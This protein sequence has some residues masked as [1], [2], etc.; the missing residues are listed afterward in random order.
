MFSITNYA[1]T[2]VYVPKGALAAYQADDVWKKFW[3]IR[4]MESGVD[5]VSKDAVR[6]YARDGFIEVLGDDS[7]SRVEVYDIGGRLV[8]GG[9]DSKIS[10][11]AKGVYVVKLGGKSTKVVL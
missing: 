10:I 4:E 6:V 8:Y 9:N 2:V 1:N 3:D 7:G 11:G 5:A